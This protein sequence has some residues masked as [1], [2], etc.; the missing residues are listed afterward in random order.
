MIRSQLVLW[1]LFTYDNRDS[2]LSHHMT[3]MSILHELLLLYLLYI[4]MVM[5]AIARFPPDFSRTE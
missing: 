1:V 2:V 5:T 3:R 4:H